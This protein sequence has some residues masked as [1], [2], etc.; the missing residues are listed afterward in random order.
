MVEPAP[1]TSERPPTHAGGVVARLDAGGPR[2]LLARARRDPTQW[3]FPKGHVEP[4][5]TREAAA[6]REVREEAGVRARIVEPLDRIVLPDGEVLLYLMRYEGD[7]EAAEGREVA[8][9]EP[10]EA[11]RRL[12][13]PES[14]RALSGAHA[15]VRSPS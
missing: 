9:C 14:R 12:G 8:W 1:E 15:R 3:V 5:E 4:G 7:A 10:D 11:Q 2:Y 6:V 13:F